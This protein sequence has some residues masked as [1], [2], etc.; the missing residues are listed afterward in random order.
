ME[1][2]DVSRKI[3]ILVVVVVAT[4]GVY[5]ASSNG[6][7]SSGPRSITL[8][9]SS[10]KA[11]FGEDT[12]RDPIEIRLSSPTLPQMGRK[13]TLEIE[14]TSRWTDL[15]SVQMT[16][17]APEGILVDGLPDGEY[18]LRLN[19]VHPMAIALMPVQEG[20][21]RIAIHLSGISPEF[22]DLGGYAQVFL[23]VPEV[24]QGGLYFGTP[25]TPLFAGA[26]IS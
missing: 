17:D 20:L 14:A 3:V 8:D 24:G 12:V 7:S 11:S 19:V 4:A 5:L 18:E 22:G 15:E 10:F 21:F 9:D 6:I 13:S 1:E 25:P 26:A 16:V 2:L 23:D